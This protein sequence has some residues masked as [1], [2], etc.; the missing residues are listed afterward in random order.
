MH[1][2]SLLAAFVILFIGLAGICNAQPPAGKPPA[3]QPAASAPTAR[4][5]KIVARYVTQN[6]VTVA[7]LSDGLTVIVKPSRLAPVVCVRFYVRAGSVYEGPSF[8][9][10]GIS[11]LTEH[12]V[13]EGAEHDSQKLAATKKIDRIELI[14]GQSNAHTSQDMTGY[15]ISAVSGKTMDCIDLI[16]DWMARQTITREAFD[17]EHGVV[18]R[19]IETHLDDP[20]RQLWET[21]ASLVY[22]PHPGGVPVIGY[23]APLKALKYEDVLRYRA[24]MYVP[25][26][27]V[28]CI[29]GD[30]DVE[31][32]L[33]RVCVATAGFE[34]GRTP[35]LALPD[36]EPIAGVRRMVRQ[37]PDMKE[38]QEDIGFLSVPLLHNDLYALDVLSYVLTQGQASR[39]VKT[40]QRRQRLVTAVDSS[41]W[42]PAWGKGIFSVSFRSD[43]DKADAAE[44][45][46]FAELR[47]IAEKGVADDELARA[48]RQKIADYV[49]SQQTV[50]SQSD[51]LA[52]D[53]LATGDVEFSRHYTD[54]IQAVTAAQVQAVARKYFTFDACA[55]TRMVPSARAAAT[56]SAPA[57][58]TQPAELFTLPNGLRVVL[59]L[60][61]N[62]DLVAM[63]L[64]CEGGVLAETD[65]TNGMGTLM[66]ALSTRGAGRLSADEIAA[67]FDEAGGG[68]SGVCGN[69][70]FTWN[71]SVLSDRCEKA[72]GIFAEIVQRPAYEEKELQ[73]LRPVLLSRIARIDE[74]PL[75]DTQRFFR[76]K[77]F[78][79]SPLRF[80]PSGSKPVISAAT[81]EQIAAYHREHVKASSCVLAIYGKFDAPAVRKQVEKA[82]ADLPQGKVELPKV[83]P[84]KVP[85]A[86]ER[87]V[88]PNEKQAA[89]VMFGSPGMTVVDLQDRLPMDVLDTIISGYRMPA[90]WLHEELRGRQLVYVVHAYNF[91]SLVPGAFI[92]YAMCQPE[93]VPEVISVID[94]DLR[95]AGD[96]LPTPEEV[97]RA[98]T[99]IL[100][101]DLLGNQELSSLAMQ[102]ALD[103]LFGFGYDFHNRLE[104]KYR[105]VTPQDVQR[106]GRKYLSGGYVVVVGTPQPLLAMPTKDAKTAK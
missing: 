72:V 38:A 98:V 7:K 44:E 65:K 47:S 79:G 101:A 91:P 57:A 9:G 43:V 96:Y 61:G 35:Y 14:G 87:F 34:T 33:N 30:V 100:T 89:V 80:L 11:H 83:E 88:L 75:E 54:R 22:G 15:Y 62:V 93:K 29:V 58:A 31:A 97:D 106:V 50:D 24:R 28:M 37:H 63:S 104:A 85:P 60:G 20:D 78:A 52:Q 74:D 19:E 95:R 55:I 41:S 59:C 68:V 48:K 86:G 2:K 13:A 26:N 6:G 10:A 81:P 67:F 103:E 17:R 3:T 5:Q 102:S 69:N 21:Q 90:G 84:R 82:F 71:A 4:P 45:A 32:V 99:T 40:I 16:A 105:A 64:V 46:I 73:I 42:T 25:Q 94:K 56:A 77:F 76:E 1:A 70:T 23:L 39:L 18:Q 49:N 12:L 36:V 8:L 66:M 53:Y 51:T 27:M 92:V